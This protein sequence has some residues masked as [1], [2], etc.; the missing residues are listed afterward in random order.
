MLQEEKREKYHKIDKFFRP[1]R[2]VA[3]PN[4]TK[5][6]VIR[7]KQPTLQSNHMSKKSHALKKIIQQLGK[8]HGLSYD[9][10]HDSY[11]Q[12]YYDEQFAREY[13]AT[14]CHVI[15]PKSHVA[16]ITWGTLANK[17]LCI[18]GS[19]VKGFGKGL[20]ANACFPPCDPAHLKKLKTMDMVY[21]C[22]K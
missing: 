8:L 22:T 18:K 10:K 20:F 11:F 19:T 3:S 9:P 7:K 17:M 4:S 1:K 2:R 6:G 14:R 16:K 13:H 5:K 12:H 15:Y 21:A